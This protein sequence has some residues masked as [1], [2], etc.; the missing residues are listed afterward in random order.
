MAITNLDEL[1]AAV[2]NWMERADLG[3]R[4]PEFIALA[5]SRINRLLDAMLLEADVALAGVAGS[6]FIPLPAGVDQVKAFWIVRPGGRAPLAQ[7]NP[8][9]LA[10]D[11]A[12][13]EPLQWAIDGPS[14]AFERPCA[15]AY[16]FQARIEGLL[17][18]TTSTPVNG[19]LTRW[20]DIY[21][22]GVLAEAAPYMLDDERL[23]V[24][25][26]K[27]EKAIR[28]V[29][30]SERRKRGNVPLRTEAAHYSGRRFDIRRG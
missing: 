20:P 19:V 17:A 5:E 25:D 28:E 8:D 18:L 13:G 7:A 2:A 24:F 29:N 12:P 14:I 16:A 27:F 21:L 9:T 26:A 22:F 4:I 10:T 23:A 15:A 3:P 11:S 1:S 6:R 30:R